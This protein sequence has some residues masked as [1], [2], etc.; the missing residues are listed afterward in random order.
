MPI[1]LTGQ[2]VLERVKGIN[3]IFRNTQKNGKSKTFIWKKRSMLFDLS[4]WYDLD[5]KHCIDVMHVKKNV[6][7]SVFALW[8]TTCLNAYINCFDCFNV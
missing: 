4:Y 8:D 7:D 3:T 6:C 5:V 2:Q 1:Q